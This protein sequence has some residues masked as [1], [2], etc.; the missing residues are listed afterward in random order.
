VDGYLVVH[1]QWTAIFLHKDDAYNLISSNGLWVSL[2]DSV[3][4]LTEKEIAKTYGDRYVSLQGTFDKTVDGGGIGLFP[5]GFVKITRISE[6]GPPR[7]VKVPNSP[8]PKPGE[9]DPFE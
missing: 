1:Y 2:N 4:G 5:G 7:L 8:G 6:L 3:L 9:R